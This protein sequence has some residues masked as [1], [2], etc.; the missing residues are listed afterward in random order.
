MAVETEALGENLAQRHSAH[1][2]LH[3]TRP[4]LE[5]RPPRPEAGDQ[6]PEIWQAYKL[7]EL[8]FSIS[9]IKLIS[10]FLSQRKFRVSVEGEMSTPRDIQAGVP[11]G[12]VLSLTLYRLYIT[13]TSQTPGVYLGFSADDA[14]IYAIDRK[15]W[16]V[17][18]KL[19]RVLSATGTWCEL[20]NIKL[21]SSTFLIDSAP[22]RLI[23][24]TTEEISF[25]CTM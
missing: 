9:P 6:P 16:F 22:L 12:S 3:M 24:H 4:G 25:S 19:Q 2:K 21:S 14:C 20:W 17:L 7:L 11:Q 15:E 8:K 5:P 13:D 23:L 18:R 1:N 10:S